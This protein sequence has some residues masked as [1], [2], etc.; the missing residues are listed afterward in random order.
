[1]DYGRRNIV[2]YCQE[3]ITTQDC[4]DP[5][6]RDYIMDNYDKWINYKKLLQTVIEDF[7]YIVNMTKPGTNRN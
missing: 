4:T 5:G 3:L 6:L 1:M 7:I 2:K